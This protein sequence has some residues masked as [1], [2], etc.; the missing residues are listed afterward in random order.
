MIILLFTLDLLSSVSGH[1]LDSVVKKFDTIRLDELNIKRYPNDVVLLSVKMDGA[2]QYASLSPHISIFHRN[3]QILVLNSNS[4]SQIA[5]PTKGHFIGKLEHFNESRVVVHFDYDGLIT[6]N[7]ELNGEIYFIEPSWRH[8]S[9]PHDFHMITYKK[10][11]LLYNFGHPETGK[12]CGHDHHPP[13]VYSFPTDTTPIPASSFEY[14]STRFKRDTTVKNTCE[15][16]LIAD[17]KFFSTVGGNSESRTKTFLIAVFER[18]NRIFKG[19]VFRTTREKYAHYGMQIRKMVIHNTPSTDRRNYNYDGAGWQVSDMLDAFGYGSDYSEEKWSDY[20]LAHL[21]TNWDFSAGVLGLA[22]VSSPISNK[23]GGICSPPYISATTGRKRNLNIGL[24]T[25]VNYGRTLLS[26]ELE[27]VSAHEIGH[28]WGSSHD[29]DNTDL[30]APPNNHFLMYPS[31]V[32]GSR[33]NNKK[34]SPCSNTAIASVLKYKSSCFV[35]ES[36]SFCGNGIVE[37]EEECDPGSEGP[38]TDPCCDEKCRFRPGA[39]CSERNSE[40]C[41]GC[42][43]AGSNFVC[44]ESKPGDP[45]D[46]INACVKEKTCNPARAICDV[47]THKDP[48]EACFD[49]GTCSAHGDCLDFCQSK[50]LS[51]CQGSGNYSCHWM[52]QD[53]D[54]QCTDKYTELPNG[55]PCA[56]GICVEGK[57]VVEPQTQTKIWMILSGLTPSLFWEWIKN[58]VVLVVILLTSIFW[59]PLSIFVNWLDHGQDQIDYIDYVYTIKKERRKEVLRQQMSTVTAHSFEMRPIHQVHLPGEEGDDNVFSLT[60]QKF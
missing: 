39:V 32:D 2:L 19:S 13:P 23:V 25:S 40:C 5:D 36:S 60:G 28:N 47:T 53:T 16:I 21:Y 17:Y 49:Q 3:F 8:I 6:G 33:T 18:I 45:L 31:A 27:L 51:L 35:E 34:F 7:I 22:Y 9:E 11:D 48:G 50:G 15:V 29:P 54:G 12:F 46:I 52:C 58:N 24:S 38:E 14:G 56:N 44:Y 20:C 43:F 1:V 4:S 37:E 26:S 59:V 41:V 30:C 57:C 10:S 42:Q 55:K